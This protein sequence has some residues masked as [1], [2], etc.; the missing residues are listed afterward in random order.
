MQ[1][2][3]DLIQGQVVGDPTLEITALASIEDAQSGE[4]TYLAPP[5]KASAMAESKASAVITRELLETDKAQI[6][7]ETPA[8]AFARVLAHWYPTSKPTAGISDQAVVE[9]DVSLGNNIT[10]SPYV[11]LSTGVRIGE[12]SVLYPGV[13]VGAGCEIGANCIL[14]PN[15]ILYAGTVLGDRVTVHAGTV[16]GADGFGYT[17]DEQGAHFKVQHIGKVVIEDDVE[18]GANSCIDR[19]KFK[20]TRIRRGTKIDNLVQIGHNCEIGEDTILVSQVGVSGSCKIGNQVALGGQVGI[21]QHVTI[22]DR[23]GVMAQS[24]VMDDIPANTIQ[25]GSPSL[26]HKDYGRST[27]LIKKLPKLAAQIREL[28]KRLEAIENRTSKS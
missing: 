24:G 8:L 25:A 3:G 28:E 12:E 20:E 26:P 17:Q 19:A 27:V 6:I 14:Y 22:G 23:V 15:V 2:I 11:V 21:S 4:L 18:I 13:V 7:C 10:L 16:I 5:R 9:E 1:Q